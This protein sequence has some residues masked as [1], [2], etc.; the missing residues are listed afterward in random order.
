M[1]TGIWDPVNEAAE[2]TMSRPEF[3]DSKVQAYCSG[4]FI[5][6]GSGQ[7]HGDSHDATHARSELFFF[8]LTF[9]FT[10]KPERSK[11]SPFRHKQ[12]AYMS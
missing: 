8:K 2:L 9:F 6:K 10:N 11:T 7:S 1:L 4:M 12:K 3:S 5:V